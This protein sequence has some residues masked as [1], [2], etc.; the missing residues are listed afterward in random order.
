MMALALGVAP[1]PADAAPA[2]STDAVRSV[3]VAGMQVAID[4]ETGR[5]RQ[6]TAAEARQL[7]QGLRQMLRPA[8]KAHVAQEHADGTLSLVLGDEYLSVYMAKVGG[9]GGLVQACVD[10]AAGAEAF[11]NGDGGAAED[12]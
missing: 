3:P 6:P 4:A 10:S 5:L 9:D 1:S 2:P 12:K 8:P 7:L 11:L